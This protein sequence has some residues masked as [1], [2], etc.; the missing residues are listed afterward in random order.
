MFEYNAPPALLKNHVIAVTGAGDGIGKAASL[1]FAGHGAT[2]ILIGRTT[3]KLE[4]VYD[5]IEQAGHPQA[6]IFPMDLRTTQSADYELLAATID[7]EFGRLTGLL[8]NAA[9]L[10][11]CAPL[12]NCSLENWL[13]VMQVNVNAGF[14]LT[15]YLLPLL[16]QEKSASV[17]F[18][19]STV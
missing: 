11:G 7:K 16:Q 13:E 12:Q 10:G 3:S 17:V 8:H 6:A 19:S 5:E 1:A 15:R 14:A 9:L 4:A 18:T 2:V